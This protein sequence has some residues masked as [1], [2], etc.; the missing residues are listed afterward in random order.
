MKRPITYQSPFR[1]KAF[2]VFAVVCLIAAGVFFA[3]KLEQIE[4]RLASDSA[5]RRPTGSPQLLSS[6]PLP[7]WDGEMCPWTEGSSFIQPAAFQQEL[8]AS[9]Q[10]AQS[11]D[12]NRAP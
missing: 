12:A 1:L 7:S 4:L 3:G 2:L 11:F 5:L 8:P 6:D 10:P 9:E